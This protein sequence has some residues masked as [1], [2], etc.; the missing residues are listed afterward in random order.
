MQGIVLRY[1]ALIFLARKASPRDPRPQ[2]PMKQVARL[3]P[4]FL[5]CPISLNAQQSGDWK[6]WEEVRQLY[7]ES[8]Y[9]EALQALESQQPPPDAP[10]SLRASY[11]YNVGNLYYRKGR[12]GAAAGYYELASTL[13]PNQEDA[14]YNLALARKALLSE[15]GRLNLDPTAGWF[16]KSL[17]SVS[18]PVFFGVSGLVLL[19]LVLFA[20]QL[21]LRQPGF[22]STLHSVPGILLLSGALLLSGLYGVKGLFD[23]NSR[24]ICVS[25]GIIRS[26]PGPQSLELTTLAEGVRIKIAGPPQ[27]S[28]NDLW[29]PIRF[30]QDGVGWF[31]A[32]KLLLLSKH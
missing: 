13:A 9:D 16:E 7:D 27:K 30:S 14:S 19:I 3:L 25:T 24:A 11:N 12:Y 1:H 17:T 8:R 4:W 26:G 28:G 23:A 22:L 32:P 6:N 20:L 15:S 2:S 29:Y 5:L 10:A 18:D 21:W 31:P